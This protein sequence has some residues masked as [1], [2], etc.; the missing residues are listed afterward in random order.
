MQFA[1]MTQKSNIKKAFKES[2]D[3]KRMTQ[4]D[5][6]VWDEIRTFLK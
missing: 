5:E 3:R 4:Q 6:K 1:H 2:Y